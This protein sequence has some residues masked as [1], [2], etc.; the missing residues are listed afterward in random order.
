MAEDD[1]RASGLTEVPIHASA[2]WREKVVTTDPP[3]YVPHSEWSIDV[4]L[5]AAA[6]VRL[7]VVVQGPGFL[8]WGL[9]PEEPSSALNLR[10]SFFPH[11]WSASDD[12]QINL[13]W[14]RVTVTDP[15]LKAD[16]RPFVGVTLP[17]EAFTGDLTPIAIVEKH[18]LELS[19][20]AFAEGDTER[21]RH[22]RWRVRPDLT[23]A[24][25][26]PLRGL[27]SG[28]QTGAEPT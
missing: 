1:N 18:G 8:R 19:W 2:E 14:Q 26:E 9:R 21:R 23:A 10:A 13:S 15:D 17:S 16:P 4:G 7:A 24:L 27:T 25:P 20:I 6:P 5:A 11:D 3:R 22:D 28:H 12:V